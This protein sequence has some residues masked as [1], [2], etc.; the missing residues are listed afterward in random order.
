[1]SATLAHCF[2]MR[3]GFGFCSGVGYGWDNQHKS[4]GADGEKYP[5]CPA[6]AASVLGF[7]LCFGNCLYCNII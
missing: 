5:Q 4:A 7:G 3:S 6:E 2:A 1:M